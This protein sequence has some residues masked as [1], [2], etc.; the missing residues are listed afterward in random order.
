METAKASETPAR[1]AD[2]K[3]TTA[4]RARGRSG[5]GERGRSDVTPKTTVSPT[6]KLL[7]SEEAILR[8]QVRRMEQCTRV[9]RYKLTSEVGK[10]Q[11]EVDHP[12]PVV[13]LAIGWNALGTAHP[14]FAEQI[15][16]QLHRANSVSGDDNLVGL[17][18]CVAAIAGMT[19]KDH[20]ETM[21]CV[22]MVSIHNATMT[23]ARRLLRAETLVQQDG[24]ERA[25]NRLART[26]TSQVETLKNYRSGGAQRITVE[27]VSVNA[28]GQA[29]VGNVIA[30]GEGAT[31]NPEATS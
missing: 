9:P 4:T 15:I 24:A 16:D 6:H 10:K 29:I 11:I 2:P 1:T 8:T 21:L 31:K 18:F 27:H 3:S 23:L 12:D 25:L 20:I 5:K 22:Q 19:P 13:G 28:G 14:I 17:N 26:F 30:G 7:P